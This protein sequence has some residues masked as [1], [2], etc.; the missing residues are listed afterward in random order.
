MKNQE[1]LMDV[2]GEVDEALV[3]EPVRPGSRR[4]IVRRVAIGG[5]CAAVIACAVFLPM[6]LSHRPA[7]VP[8]GQDATQAQTEAQTEVQIPSVTESAEKG[9]AALLTAA[10]YPKAFAYPRDGDFEGYEVWADER[11]SKIRQAEDYRES[12][13]RFVKDSAEVFLSGEG[14][15]NAV[16]SPL[17]LYLALGMSAEVTGGNTR[18]QILSALSQKDMGTLRTEAQS[19]WESCYE[20][21]GMAKCILASS[22]W[23][24]D[25]V[26]YRQDTLDRLSASYYASAF[27]G[28]PSDEG[29]SLSLQSWLDEQTDGLL[30]D[31]TSGLRMAPDMM[32]TLA[33]TVNYSGKWEHPFMADRTRPAVFHAPSGDV[34]CDFMNTERLTAYY[35]GDRFASVSLPLENNGEMRLI[36]PDEGVDA[37]ELLRDEEALRYMMHFGMDQYEN[38]KTAS[39]TIKIPKFDISDGIDLEDGMKRLGITE[40]FDSTAADFSPLCDASGL[41]LEKAEQDTRVMID[42]DGCRASSMTVMMAAGAA[43][44]EEF[45]DFIVDRPFVFEIVSES[46]IPLFVG[47][48]NDPC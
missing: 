4:R 6:F 27:S 33:S 45:V 44:P 38:H 9:S 21:D 36:L 28:D 12:F 7:V 1:I 19:L 26:G 37:R 29:Y 17:S 47:V 25:K 15:E 41:Y 39:V 13:G 30:T 14:R 48:V 5:V 3:P 34:T 40:V 10:V 11:L 20:N 24:N 42:E 43:P 35:W 46:G 18:Q 32:L 23:T 31:Y 8:V 22:L 16:Y 2:I